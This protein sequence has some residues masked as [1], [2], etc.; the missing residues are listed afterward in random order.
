[1]TIYTFIKLSRI[2]AGG[3]GQEWHGEGDGDG[4]DD[5]RVGGGA[6]VGL[7]AHTLIRA[8]ARRFLMASPPVRRAKP[9]RRAAAHK[10]SISS[11]G[12]L[13]DTSSP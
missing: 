1:M 2:R 4:D 6:E 3:G 12:R 7:A 9:P 8:G 10:S 11:D 13:F 5:V